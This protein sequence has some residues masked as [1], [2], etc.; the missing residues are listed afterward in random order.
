MVKCGTD[1]TEIRAKTIRSSG[2]LRNT[3]TT[4][5]KLPYNTAKLYWYI[6]MYITISNYQEWERGVAMYDYG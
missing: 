4:G 3:E 1:Y 6:S 5:N 2:F